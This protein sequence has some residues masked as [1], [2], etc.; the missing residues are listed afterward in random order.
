VSAVAAA[1]HG[2]ASYRRSEALGGACFEVTFPGRIIEVDDQESGFPQA[3]S[4]AL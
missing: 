3:E 1:H 4:R 2:S